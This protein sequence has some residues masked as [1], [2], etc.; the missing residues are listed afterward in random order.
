[1]SRD[2]CT[3]SQFN[4]EVA[5]HLWYK[6]PN[7]Q[8]LAIHQL[9]SSGLAD[10]SELL[11]GGCSAGAVA[12]PLLGDYV[13]QTVRRAAAQRGRLKNG[14]NGGNAEVDL[15]WFMSIYGDLW[16]FMVI[17]VFFCDM[18]WSWWFL[19][20]LVDFGGFLWFMRIYGEVFLCWCL[21][22]RMVIYF[23][24]CFPDFMVILT[25]L[26]RYYYHYWLYHWPSVWYA[27]WEMAGKPSIPPQE[28]LPKNW[29]PGTV[30]EWLGKQHCL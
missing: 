25:N 20:I 15:W 26:N 8:R 21:W 19:L 14:G 11:L 30:R 18:W 13:A 16:W 27:G 12:A 2:F 23:S 3:S 9:L 29:T 6:S 28:R 7:R 17:Y 5:I 1:M 24:F 4:L 22:Q 10:A